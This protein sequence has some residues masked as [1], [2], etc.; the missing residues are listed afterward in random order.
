[1]FFCFLPHCCLNTQVI[2]NL[3]IGV[4]E[5]SQEELER[6]R[7]RGLSTKR[8][9]DY[10]INKRCPILLER[11]RDRGEREGERGKERDYLIDERCPIFFVI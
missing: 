9:R 4:M 1:L 2:S 11:K 7:E 5:W 8:E 10:L 3:S 6:E